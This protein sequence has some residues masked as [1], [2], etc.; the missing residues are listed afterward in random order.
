MLRNGHQD[1]IC[2][3]NCTLSSYM[4]FDAKNFPELLNC[5]KTRRRKTMM[6][7]QPP[8]SALQK[9]T[10]AKTAAMTFEKKCSIASSRNL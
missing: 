7:F 6:L 3:Y 1:L 5:E 4:T 10:H 9:R 8:L 2:I